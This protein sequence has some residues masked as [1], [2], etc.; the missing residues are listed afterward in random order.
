MSC[1][2]TLG[3]LSLLAV[4]PQNPKPDAPAAPPAAAKTAT[5]ATTWKVLRTFAVGGDGGWDYVAIDSEARR[6]YVPRANRVLVLDADTGKQTGEIADTAGVHGVAL[7]PQFGR[8]FTSNG[9]ADTCTVFDLKDGKVQKTIATGKNPD[10]LVVDGNGKVFVNV[11]DKSEVVRI[12]AGKNAV[13]QH[14]PLAPG[15]E[16]TG[17]AIDAE[18]HLLFAACSNEKMVVLD[19]ETG[20]VLASPAIGKR[21]DGAAFDVV[22]GC[23][24]SANGEGTLSVIATRGNQPFTVVQTLPTAPGARTLVLDPKSRQ[25][26]LPTADF[27]TAPADASAS[28]RGR[29]VKADS[30]RIVVVGLETH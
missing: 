22:S 6:L 23:A 10:A 28:R 15:A 30:F 7:A 9:R 12:D 24:I 16:P 19:A 8:G 27:E 5:E 25:L 29:R 4:V 2:L 17:L 18:H 20:K 3:V 1:S 11:E 21:T 14:L 13:E 26:Y